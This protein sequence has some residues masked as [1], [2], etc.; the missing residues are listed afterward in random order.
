M[1][2]EKTIILSLLLSFSSF[3]GIAATVQCPAKANITST[4]VEKDTDGIS[5]MTYC[6]PSA[7]DCKWKGFDPMAIIGSKVKE[8]LNSGNRPTKN[9]GLTYCDY[10]LET[11]D[12]IRMSLK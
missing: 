7:A 2:M 4:V 3:S 8:L 10:K 1:N 11:G 6:S 12:Q 9:N 5:S